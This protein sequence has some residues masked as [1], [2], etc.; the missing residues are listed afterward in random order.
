M[1]KAAFSQSK[2]SKGEQAVNKDILEGKWKQVR[3]KI[4]ETWGDLTDDE[5]D[6]VSG[7]YDV[8]VGKLQ[9]KYGYSRQE[10]EKEIDDFLNEID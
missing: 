7:K 4:K 5:L 2:F 10:A 3:G 8:L 1:C 6:Q 9:E